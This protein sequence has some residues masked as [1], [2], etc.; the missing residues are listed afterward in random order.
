MK[1]LKIESWGEGQGDFV[2][3]NEGDFNPETHTHFGE[4]KLTAKE[5]KAQSEAEKKAADDAALLKFICEA[6]T[7]KGIAF[8]EDEALEELQAKLDAEA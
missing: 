1:L 8:G 2:E 5:K 4:K 6:L 7:E 3:I